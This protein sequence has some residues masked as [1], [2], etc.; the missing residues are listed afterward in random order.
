MKKQRIYLII[1]FVLLTYIG[2]ESIHH[3]FEETISIPS[4]NH[5]E[6]YSLRMLPSGDL[7][8]EKNE[9]LPLASYQDYWGDLSVVESKWIDERK[10]SIT[11]EDESVLL[12][13]LGEIKIVLPKEAGQSEP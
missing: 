4:F 10:V 8:F 9:F 3:V 1:I 7:I 13:T 11:L 6:T 12:I 5:K 2:G